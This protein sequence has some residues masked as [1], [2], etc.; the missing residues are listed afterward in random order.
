LIGFGDDAASLFIG[1]SEIIECCRV[2]AA[3]AQR[4]AHL[5]NIL[6]HVIQ[7]EHLFSSIE[8]C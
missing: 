8:L 6:P 3:R 7:I 4:L 2:G 5:V 1:A